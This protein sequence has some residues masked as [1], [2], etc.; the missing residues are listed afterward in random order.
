LA[1]VILGSKSILVLERCNAN[2]RPER[3]GHTTPHEMAAMRDHVTSEDVV[4]FAKALLDA[5]QAGYPRR[6]AKEYAARLGVPLGPR[7]AVKLLLEYG[8]DPME[9]DAEPWATPQAL[10]EKME[11]ESVLAVLRNHGR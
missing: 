9:A 6:S 1:N 8:A 2:V 11:R 3:F 4:E 5:G 7:R 10:V